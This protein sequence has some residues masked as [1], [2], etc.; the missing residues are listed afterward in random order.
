[1]PKNPFV[2]LVSMET[3]TFMT[4]NRLIKTWLLKAHVLTQYQL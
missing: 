2:K 3:L 1:M 4:I